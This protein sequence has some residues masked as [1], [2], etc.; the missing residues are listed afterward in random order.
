MDQPHQR[1]QQS[2]ALPHC[3]WHPAIE[4][5]LSCSRCGKNICTQ[6]VVQAPVGI[7]CPE[8]GKAVPMPTYDVQPTY[9][10][11]A[12]AVAI[13]ITVG[14][15]LLWVLLT[16][17]FLDLLRI[18]FLPILGA[19]PVGYAG[20]ELL[21]RAVNRKRGKG[22]AWIAAASVIGAFLVSYLVHPFPFSLY[23]LIS[24]GIGIFVAVQRVR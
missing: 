13:A 12:V 5:G 14:G 11:R 18:S 17:F 9:Y 20:G 2:D 23:G 21:S 1:E 16:M 7:R 22:L 24:I 3:Y 19:I 8:C 6:C 15:G 4:T 10:A